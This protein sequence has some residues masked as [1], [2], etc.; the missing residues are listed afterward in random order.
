MRTIRLLVSYFV[1]LFSVFYADPIDGYWQQKV[2]YNMEITLVDTSQ[3]L[4]GY[5]TI[6]YINNSPDSLDR[7]YMHLYPNAFQLESVK[8]REYIGNA[9]RASRAKYFKDRLDGFTSKFDIHDFSVALPE[10]GASW[11]HKI[12][13]LD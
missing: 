6:K 11:I 7:I 13:I 4:T 1:C 2:D 9:G 5:T 3:Q 12:L 10:E 8:Y